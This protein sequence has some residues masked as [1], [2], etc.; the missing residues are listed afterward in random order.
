MTD[1]TC[2]FSLGSNMKFKQ[3]LCKLEKILNSH[4]IKIINPSIIDILTTYN[5]PQ[6]SFLMFNNKPPIEQ[7]TQSFQVTATGYNS[8]G[9]YTLTNSGNIVSFSS[10]TS[11]PSYI[12]FT[13]SGSLTV[14]NL[15]SGQ[16]LNVILVGGGG[17]GGGGGGK[18]YDSITNGGGGGGGGTGQYTST[19]ISSNGTFKIIVGK[20]GSGGSGSIDN[21]YTGKGGYSSSISGNNLYSKVS[22]GGGGGGGLVEKKP[23]KAQGGTGGS[24]SSKGG[25]G[26]GVDTTE[27]NGQNGKTITNSTFNTNLYIGGGGGGGSNSSTP[28]EPSGKPQ[29]NYIYEEYYSNKWG[30]GNYN[31]GGGFSAAGFQNGPGPNGPAKLKNYYQFV[32]GGGGGGAGNNGT[33]TKGPASGGAGGGGAN[34]CVLVYWN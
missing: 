33:S 30:G 4:L 10:P 1:H 24:G 21:G 14:S 9:S 26:S 32:G 3:E 22:G 12:L 25:N 6:Y 2:R 19:K 13:S 31:S 11:N 34:G 28:G 8:Q 15:P 17:G 20:G 27:G 16:T 23:Q 5:T 29:G 7:T 18:L